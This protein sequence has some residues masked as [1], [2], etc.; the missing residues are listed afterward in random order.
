MKLENQALLASK[1]NEVPED[2]WDLLVHQEKM[3]DLDYL[4]KL[5]LLD[6]VDQ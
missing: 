4:V 3:L 1:V 5:D 6:L 2:L